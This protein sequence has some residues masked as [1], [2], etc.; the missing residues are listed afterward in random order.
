MAG[1]VFR[2]AR[3][4]KQP[5][6]NGTFR[7]QTLLQVMIYTCLLIGTVF[8]IRTES[9]VYTIVK[10]NTFQKKVKEEKSQ[11]TCILIPV[12]HGFGTSV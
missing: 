7:Q 6:E 10:D 5:P 8:C 4:M 2:G 11:G 12:S 3:Q 1:P 9:K